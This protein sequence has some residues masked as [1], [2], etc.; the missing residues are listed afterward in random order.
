M[1]HA[2]TLLTVLAF[3]SFASANLLSN[4]DFSS[5]TFVNAST[6]N[7]GSPSLGTWIAPDSSWEFTGTIAQHGSSA[8]AN[9]FGT[10]LAQVIAAPADGT[11]L[12]F[13]FDYV[14]SAGFGLDV[15][16]Y[17]IDSSAGFPGTSSNPGSIAGATNFLTSVDGGDGDLDVGSTSTGVFNTF[18]ENNVTVTGGHDYLVVSFEFLGA[19]AVS[20]PGLVERAIDNVSLVPEPATMS[21]LGLGGL[22]LL[23]RRR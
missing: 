15:H 10:G 4:G 18:V 5:T 7:A 2:L 20:D 21:L 22:A 19:S 1:R 11:V 9:A 12:T 6:I 23:R 17:G 3:A 8:D 16:V 14:N 13:S